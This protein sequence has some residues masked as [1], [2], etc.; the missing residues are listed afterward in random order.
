MGFTGLNLV[1]PGQQW[2]KTMS[3]GPLPR[4]IQTQAI[5][6]TFTEFIPAEQET[7]P[8]APTPSEVR[9]QAP[10]IASLRLPL[11]L[12][13]NKQYME[14]KASEVAVLLFQGIPSPR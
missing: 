11:P 5:L 13:P 6:A 2:Y 8:S 3:L 14:Y 1:H 9:M 7:G 4:T 10:T 12:L